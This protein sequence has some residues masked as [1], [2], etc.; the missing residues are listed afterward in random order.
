MDEQH[1]HKK[2]EKLFFWTYLTMLWSKFYSNFACLSLVTL[3]GVKRKKNHDCRL[4]CSKVI[5]I[6]EIYW[7]ILIEIYWFYAAP[8]S[9]T[10]TFI[11]S[12]DVTWLLTSCFSCLFWWCI[13]V[14]NVTQRLL[15]WSYCW[16]KLKIL[17]LHFYRIEPL[18]YSTAIVQPNFS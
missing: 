1:R 10:Q 12:K 8:Y 15:L 17:T 18:P 13:M 5:L 16:K 3:Q 7:L 2:S 14:Y 6:Y 11:W 9:R 4:S